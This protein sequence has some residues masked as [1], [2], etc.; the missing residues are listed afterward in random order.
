MKVYVFNWHTASD[1][2]FIVSESQVF[3]TYEK[4]RESFEVWKC[5]EKKYAETEGWE[6]DSDEEGHFEASVW[7]DYCNNHTEGTITEQELL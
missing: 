7:A 5:E 2:E 1:G 6:I 4:A 3:K